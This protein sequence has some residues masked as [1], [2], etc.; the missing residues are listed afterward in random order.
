MEQRSRVAETRARTA[1]LNLANLR[2]EN[3][4]LKRKLNDSN[5]YTTTLEAAHEEMLGTINELEIRLK[6]ASEHNDELIK[7]ESNLKFKLAT[8]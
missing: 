8:K 7:N 1:E 2:S 4:D 3:S 6:A 5:S